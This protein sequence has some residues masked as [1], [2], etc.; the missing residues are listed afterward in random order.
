MGVGGIGPA[1]FV[2]FLGTGMALQD[3]ARGIEEKRKEGDPLGAWGELALGAAG[4]SLG[5]GP[6][7]RATKKIAGKFLSPLNKL[8]KSE[9]ERMMMEEALRNRAKELPAQRLLNAPKAREKTTFEMQNELAQKRAALPVDQGGLGLPANNTAAQRAE[10]MG[11]NTPAYHSTKQ[12]PA[13]L[14]PRPPAS[15]RRGTDFGVHVGNA[16]QANSAIIPTWHENLL[17]SQISRPDMSDVSKASYMKDLENSYSNSQV[18]PLMVNKGTSFEVP[19]FGR[20]N[21]SNNMLHHVAK[22]RGAYPN[23]ELKAGIKT[24]DEDALKDLI[25]R[26]ATASDEEHTKN[27]EDIMRERNY[28]SIAY[29]NESEGRRGV[30]SLMFT[31]PDRIRSRFAAFDPFRR[32]AAIAAAM[33]VAAPDLLAAEPENKAVGGSITSDDLILEERML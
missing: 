2:P 16:D 27:I 28:D 32:N 7:Y 33:G 23:Y 18:M 15:S 31:D 22:E 19:D 4:A 1:D 8:S 3:T 11:F 26:S 21:S 14:L 12:D 9:Y 25:N 20:W 24:N 13:V 5:I 10:A 17:R 6:T 29:P 30:E